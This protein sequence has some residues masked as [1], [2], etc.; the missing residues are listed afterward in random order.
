MT[1][2]GS[3]DVATHC[4]PMTASTSN[5]GI[6][7]PQPRYLSD[8]AQRGR[9]FLLARVLQPRHKAGQDA[10][11]V[12]LADADHKG[13]AELVAVCLVELGEG[14]ELLGREAVQASRRLLPGR[15]GRQRA[16]DRRTASQ[17]GVGLDQRDLPLDRRALQRGTGAPCS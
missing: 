13:K 3:R 10:F 9:H 14:R 4:P 5:D 2:T 6:N 16:G 17:V 8:L 12:M 15:F 7:Q 1:E 11:L